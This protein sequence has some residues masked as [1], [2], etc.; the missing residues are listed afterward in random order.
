M[1]YVT[2]TLRNTLIFIVSRSYSPNQNA[3]LIFKLEL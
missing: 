2:P 3:N 1:A